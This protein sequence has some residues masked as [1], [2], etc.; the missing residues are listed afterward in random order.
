M[1][2]ANKITISRIIISIVIMILLLFPFEGL[3][4]DLPSYIVKGHIYVE[5]K[6][7]IAGVLFIIASLTDFFDGYVARKYDMVTDFGKMVDAISDK[8]LTNSLLVILASTGMISPIIAVIFIVRDIAVDTI[9]MIIGNK[10]KAVAAIKIAKWKT[11]TLMLGLTFTLFYNLPFELIGN[12]NSFRVS[13]VLLIISTV[14]SVISAF[15]YYI[16]AKPYI[17]VR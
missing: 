2:L 1:N 6:Y 17:E 3:G 7:I 11:A 8:M 15:Q 13:D 5:L 14:L 4:I 16:M 12:G 9:K 10:G